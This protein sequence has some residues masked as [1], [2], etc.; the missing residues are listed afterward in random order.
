MQKVSV[1][2]L[3]LWIH[4]Q[5]YKMKDNFQKLSN[6]YLLQ[7]NESSL[8]IIFIMPLLHVFNKYCYT[9]NKNPFLTFTFSLPEITKNFICRIL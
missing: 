5:L 9:N 6:F 2:N 8:K 1:N 7:E 3:L 4:I